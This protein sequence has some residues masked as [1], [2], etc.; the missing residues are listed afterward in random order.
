MS[1]L[2][3]FIPIATDSEGRTVGDALLYSYVVGTN[4]PKVTYSNQGLTIPNANPLQSDGSG[5]FFDVFLGAGGYKLVVTDQ[6]GVVLWSQDNYYPALDTGD[7]ANIEAMI[8]ATQQQISQSQ[9]VYSDSGTADNYV[10]SIINNAEIPIAYGTAMIIY[11]SVTN[12]NTGGA[13]FVNVEGLGNK[14]L[15][16]LD[17]SNPVAN[18]LVPGDLYGFIYLFGSFYFFFKSGLITTP[19]IKDGAVTT[20]KI[21]DLG[22]TT[23]K[24]ADNGVTL[25]KL[26]AGTAFKLIGYS[27]IGAAQEYTNPMRLLSSGAFTAAASVSFILSTL[28]SAQSVDNVYL[29]RLV[30]FQPAGD[31]S[32]LYL[33]A[34]TDAGGS[35]V[36]TNYYYSCAG[37]DSGGSAVANSTN[38]GAAQAQIIALGGNGATYALSNAADETA[39]LDLFITNCNTGTSVRPLIFGA[40][41]FWAANANTWV[42]QS[43]SSSQSVAGDYDAIKL[44]W[45]GGGNFVAA[46]K[47]YLFKIPNVI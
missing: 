22:V 16:M 12:A 25:G 9:G 17:N 11:F 24:I 34:S 13:A 44:T 33:T 47:Y 36:A 10:L 23:G 39:T 20:A 46:G 21:E 38:N 42:R 2:T 26:A 5:K 4:T 8:A 30:G 14:S 45:E 7:L 41:A 28:D 32:C 18:F 15:K 31:D 27:S 1:L 43:V 35:Y 19:L 37:T 40:G 29:L 6:F 3:S